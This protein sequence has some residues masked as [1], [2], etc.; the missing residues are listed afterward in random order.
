MVWFEPETF[1]KPPSARCGHTLNFCP[2]FS[3]LVV[4]GGKDD[5]CLVKPFCNDICLLN[6]SNMNWLKLKIF[7]HTIV[8]PRA[9]HASGIISSLFFKFF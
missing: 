6:L 7:G 5:K 1:G 4:S 8:P 3:L 2:Q 9:F